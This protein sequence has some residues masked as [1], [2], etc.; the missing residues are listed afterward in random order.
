M[1]CAKCE[2]KGLARAAAPDPFR[3]RNA[4]GTLVASGSKVG[5]ASTGPARPGA[6]TSVGKAPGTTN[7]LLSAKGRYAPTALKCKTCGSN[8]QQ[9]R[10]T[11]CQS[12]AYKRGICAI[13]GKMVMDTKMHKMSS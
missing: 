4:Q 13:C 5:V 6:S 2:K 11:Y 3:N 12:C 8:T 9:D 10:A 7:K 1:V